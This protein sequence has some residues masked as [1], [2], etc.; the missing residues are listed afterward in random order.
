MK[1]PLLWPEERRSLSKLTVHFLTAN[2]L[3]A[4]HLATLFHRTRSQIHSVLVRLRARGLIEAVDVFRDEAVSAGFEYLW[5]LT[6]HARFH[7]PRE[8]L[9][10][11]S[12][13]KYCRRTYPGS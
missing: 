5:R 10:G 12:R 8:V 4:T 7:S 9:P 2:A 6:D 1:Q 3:T 11:T 13:C